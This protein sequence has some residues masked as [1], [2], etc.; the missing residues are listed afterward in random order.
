MIPPPMPAY[1]TLDTR[2]AKMVPAL[3]G[4]SSPAG[5]LLG[6]V[7]QEPSSDWV[8]QQQQLQ[9]LRGQYEFDMAIFMIAEQ[10]VRYINELGE[11]QVVAPEVARECAG[12]YQGIRERALERL[13]GVAEQ[14][15]RLVLEMQNHIVR[16][17]ALERSEKLLEGL[18][19]Q[20]IISKTVAERISAQLEGSE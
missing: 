20:G 18:V 11:Q 1:E 7:M 2:W 9:V 15:P 12:T 13:Q 8:K 14:Y 16:Q 19:A 4:S 5:E 10:V 6:E 17:G 3:A